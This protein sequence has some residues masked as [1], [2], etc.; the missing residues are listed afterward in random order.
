MGLFSKK[1]SCS[2][3]KEIKKCKN[4]SD[5]Y[6]C[7]ECISKCGTYISFNWKT[8]SAQQVE[9]RINKN[10]E[11]EHLKSFFSPTQN[12]DKYLEIDENNK[13]LR[14]PCNIF[15]PILKFSDIIDFELLENGN[16]ISKGGLGNAVIGGVLFGG[17]G[18]IVGG[19]IGKKKTTQ[20][21]TQLSIKI[22][23][24]NIYFPDVYINFLTT[25]KIK[26]NSILFKG[27]SA[28]AQ[29]VLSLLTLIS[30]NDN[31]TI[32]SYSAAD[33][34]LKFKKLLDDGIITQ[35]EFNKKKSQLLE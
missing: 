5:G 9:D 6:I 30:S 27:Y 3:C 24:K 14:I 23:T 2:L 25:G 26:S 31:N 32:S 33:E 11:N 17:V 28:S 4:L 15:S 29:K 22:I 35:D 20:E 34:I 21:I 13:L 8:V 18:A 16:T 19:T 7:N 1:V 10:I 12:V